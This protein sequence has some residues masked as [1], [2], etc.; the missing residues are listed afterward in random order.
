M[1]RLIFAWALGVLAAA[2]LAAAAGATIVSTSGQMT[3]I[4]PPPSVD[5]GALQSNTTMYAF[6]EQQCV[7]TA[8]D[9]PVDITVPGTYDDSSDLTPG[10][11]PAGTL[12][13]S[14]FVNADKVGTQPPRIELEGSIVTDADI[15][16]IAI[17]QHS[18]N[19][20]DVLGAP[21]TI[22]PTGKFGRGL[23]PD[24]QN[25]FVIEQIDKRTVVVHSDVRVHTDQ[26]RVITRCAETLGAQGCTPGYWKQPQHFDSW[27]VYTQTDTYDS[28][29]GVSAF[30]VTLTLLQALEQGG[31]G[32]NA[33]GR[34]SVA[35]LL[36]A[37]SPNVNYPITSA[38]VIALT[39]AAINSGNKT[40]ITQTKDQLESYNQLGCPIS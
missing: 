23:N 16:G 19:V 28:V 40:L 4:S 2:A 27:T 3:L 34:H 25:D 14:H 32:I 21:G 5:I 37:V 13:S 9:L 24:D 22:Y 6:N 10:V 31:G 18:L 30:P 8:A 29:F 39:Q 38:Q 15:L 7:R 20:T 17:L 12:V 35:G 1:R 33:L 26:V 11:I 36:N